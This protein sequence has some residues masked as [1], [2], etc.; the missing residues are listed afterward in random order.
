RGY[1]CTQL[2]DRRVTGRSDQLYHHFLA[3][4]WRRVRCVGQR[5]GL[6]NPVAELRAYVKAGTLTAFQYT[7]ILQQS[8]SGNYRGDAEVALAA[9]LPYAGQPVARLKTALTDGGAEVFRQLL[10]ERFHSGRFC[11]LSVADNR[12]RRSHCDQ[13]R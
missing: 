13:Y 5:A 6:G 3:G 1:S 10:V 12:Y 2:H 4:H 8:I 9:Q 11:W 7:L